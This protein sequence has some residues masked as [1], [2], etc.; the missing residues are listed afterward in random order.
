[1]RYARI[2]QSAL[3]IRLIFLPL[4]LLLA[5]AIFIGLVSPDPQYIQTSSDKAI[6]V[7]VPFALLGLVMLA[8]RTLFLGVF[9]TEDAVVVRTW[10]TTCSIPCSAVVKV[11]PAA[12]ESWINWGNIDGTGD[13][14]NVLALTWRQE[15]GGTKTRSFST[16]ANSRKRTAVIAAVVQAFA[17]HQASGQA[18]ARSYAAGED[19]QRVAVEALEKLALRKSRAPRH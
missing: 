5:V 4:L 8:V 9:F 6:E 1:M 11:Q 19:Y 13:F 18:S 14:I 12:W 16:T 15:K 7:F 3:T 10:V 17:E 2:K